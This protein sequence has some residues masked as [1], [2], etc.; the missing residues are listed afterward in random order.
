MAVARLTG[1]LIWN[2]SGK[3]LSVTKQA[4]V[5]VTGMSAS[6][7]AAVG[8]GAT[9]G[10]GVAPGKKKICVAGAEREAEATR[11]KAE[12]ASVRREKARI[13]EEMRTWRRYPPGNVGV[14][15][16]CEAAGGL[17]Q[18][19]PNLRVVMVGSSGLRRWGKI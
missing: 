17:G 10:A 7:L 2:P 14:G 3:T 16:D 8:S 6:A 4:K 9:E 18:G 15:G 13:L 12:R 11:A 19:A 1:S 5:G